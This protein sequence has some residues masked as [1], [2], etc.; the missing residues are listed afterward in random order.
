MHFSLHCVTILFFTSRKISKN[1]SL[2][3]TDPIEHAYF[4]AHFRKDLSLLH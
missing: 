4:D 3:L 1:L 2:L